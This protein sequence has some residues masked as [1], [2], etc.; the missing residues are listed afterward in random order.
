MEEFGK[1]LYAGK[2][3]NNKNGIVFIILGILLCIG[4]NFVYAKTTVLV[5]GGIVAL[6]GLYLLIF[7]R[8]EKF[9]IYEKAI[10]MTQKGQEYAILK[11]QINRIEY[12]E[13]N[14][15]RSPVKSYYPV[16]VLEGENKILINKV[17]NS[18]INQEFKRTIESYM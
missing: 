17:F 4:A 10:T 5:M 1:L 7:N 12:E 8:S 9:S 15:R 3:D 13:I 14:V 6:I 18:V 16:L 11:E 2:T